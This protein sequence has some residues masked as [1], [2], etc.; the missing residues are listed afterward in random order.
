MNDY[1]FYVAPNEEDLGWEFTIGELIESEFEAHPENFPNK[2]EKIG[3]LKDLI[4]DIEMCI[5]IIEKDE[6]ARLS[7]V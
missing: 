7:E 2:S 6:N 4:A 3:F 5:S 1:Y